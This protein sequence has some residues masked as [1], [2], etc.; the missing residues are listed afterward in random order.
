MKQLLETLENELAE[1]KED[2][3]KVTTL[4]ITKIKNGEIPEL[5]FN[6]Y[7]RF[8]FVYKANQYIRMTIDTNIKI[9]YLDITAELP[10]DI[11]EIKYD[12]NIP[13]KTIMNYFEEIGNDINDKIELTKFSKVDY[14]IENIII[15]H[16]IKAILSKV[17]W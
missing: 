14:S 5:F 7:K 11:L 6:E 3:E 15:P 10:F 13:E 4:I 16:N 8:S 1:I 2:A 12:K 17:Q 9:K